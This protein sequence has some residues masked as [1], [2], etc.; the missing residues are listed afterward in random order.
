MCWSTSVILMAF[1]KPIYV[2]C[3]QCLN[4]VVMSR[5]YLHSHLCMAQC[6]K[7]LPHLLAWIYTHFWHSISNNVWLLPVYSKFKI[8]PLILVHKFVRADP[9]ITFYTYICSFQ[10]VCLDNAYFSEGG[11]WFLLIFREFII[12]PQ[13][14]LQRWWIR[15]SIFGNYSLVLP[16]WLSLNTQY[17]GE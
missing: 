12:S 4:S 16:M 6:K 15:L 9:E 3:M 14:G 2:W 7:C 17:W 10:Y 1:L 13:W 11:L 5:Y 8:I